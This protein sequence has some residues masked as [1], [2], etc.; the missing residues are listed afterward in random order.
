MTGKKLLNAKI[1][2]ALLL[3]FIFPAI[4]IAQNVTVSAKLD[5]TLMVIGGQMDFTIEISQ[6]DNIQ[7]AFPNISD[8][9]TKN[10]EVVRES[11]PDTT[12]LDNQRLAITK[13]YRITSF[14]SGLHYIPPLRFEYMEG[15][16]A[17]RAETQS[18]ALLVVNPFT[19]VD[20]SKGFFDIKLPFNL[21]FL[22][23]ELWRFKYWILSILIIGLLAYFG[24]YF[25]KKREIPVKE[26]FFPTKPKEPPHIM[27]LKS[28]DKIKSE[29]LWQSGQVKSYYSQLTDTLRRY[30]E[31]RYN[32]PAM[33]QTTG[34]IMSALK[35]QELPDKNLFH[36]M[37]T[38]LSTA[39]LAKFAKYEPLPDE[40]D[41]CLISAYFF[42]N[43]TKEEP[44]PTREALEKELKE[45]SSED[46]QEERD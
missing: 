19:E 46:K 17:R 10:I 22:L 6:P 4:H 18:S 39:D 27:A 15:E 16:L 20:P 13:R 2:P 8:T 41:N 28:L 44:V 3:M 26:I 5:S 36:K 37:E 11:R 12:H 32:F 34:E 35:Y 30:M 9:I 14:D 43:Q 7:L 42:V 23:S 38:V 1:L 21:P 29:K 33:E 45:A 31:D 24:Y 25:Y 40:N